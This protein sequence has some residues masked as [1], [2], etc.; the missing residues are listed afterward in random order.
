MN[1]HFAIEFG[2]LA[3]ESGSPEERATFAE[4]VISVDGIVVTELEDLLAKTVR[5]GAR[6]SAYLLAQWLAANWWRLRWEPER[7]SLSWR[8]SH[9]VAAAGGGYQWPNLTLSSDGATVGVHA[10]ATTRPYE[11]MVRYLNNV[12]VGLPA[13]AFE[14]AVDQFVDGV[15]ARLASERPRDTPAKLGK[16]WGEVCEERGDPQLTRWRKLEA[17]LGFDPDEA[18]DGLIKH[19][20]ALIDDYGASAI[21]EMAAESAER[22]A[23]D[24]TVL[25]DDV[26]QRSPVVSIKQAASLRR[27][28]RTETHPVGY[29]WQRA[30][31]AAKI[32]R[33]AWGLGRGPVTTEN[34]CGLLTVPADVVNRQDVFATPTIAGFRNG[35]AERVGVALRSKYPTGRRFALARLIG[36]FL[37]SEETERLLPATNARTQRQKFQRAFAQE[38][39]CPFADLQAY[40]GD[41][42]ITDDAIEDAA[43]HFDVSPMLVRTELV[44]KNLLNRS[45]L[46]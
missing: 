5:P 12:D 13:G 2:W 30:E 42:T 22:A 21:E 4:I 20:Q 16:L 14:H 15:L 33:E 32:V 10:R 25:W 17:I 27:C 24:I 3:T 37:V 26:R 34:L 35:D 1:D 40:L 44:N 8:M 41:A 39:L 18:P 29:P 36:D 45:L 11:H 28:L 9:S 7:N 23:D 43:M 31:E 38:F 19:L 46:E 6:L